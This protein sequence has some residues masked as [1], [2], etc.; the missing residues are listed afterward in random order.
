MGLGARTLQA[1]PDL[2]DRD[3]LSAYLETSSQPNV[4]FYSALGFE[5]VRH[6]SIAHGAG[7]DLWPMN[8]APRE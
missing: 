2:A 8:R 6:W 5:I 4:D 7:P 1:G 3:Q